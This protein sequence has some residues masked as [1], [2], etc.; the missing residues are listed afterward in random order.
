MGWSCGS[1]PSPWEKRHDRQ[2]LSVALGDVSPE[3]TDLLVAAM[4]LAAKTAPTT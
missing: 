3:A 4:D 2:D 1:G